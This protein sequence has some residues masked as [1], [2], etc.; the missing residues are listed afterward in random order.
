MYRVSGSWSLMKRI[1]TS[2]VSLAVQPLT[3]VTVSTAVTVPSWW[4]ATTG[5]WT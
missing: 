4:K 1:G 2:A 5:F 3:S